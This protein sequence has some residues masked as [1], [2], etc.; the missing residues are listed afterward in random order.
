LG[1]ALENFN[2]IGEWRDRDSDAGNVPIDAS[3]RLANG[4][5]INGVNELRA[6]LVERPEQ[7]AQVFTE[8]LLMYAIGRGVEAHD[9]PA[10]R[11]IVDVAAADNY[12]FSSIINGI[13]TSDQFQLMTVPADSVLQVGSR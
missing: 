1:L 8:K 5:P 4:Q 2:A 11:R 9:M 12:S 6:A 7:F 10:V 3:G 13:I